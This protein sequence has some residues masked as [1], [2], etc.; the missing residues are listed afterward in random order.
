MLKKIIIASNIAKSLLFKLLN[1]KDLKKQYIEIAFKNLYAALTL[2][3]LSLIIFIE[4]VI[5]QKIHLI[6]SSAIYFNCSVISLCAILIVG[7][8]AKG[9]WDDLQYN[10]INRK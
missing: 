3:I 6:S 4:T 5:Q 2:F 1:E 8:C 9:I 7:V 10:L